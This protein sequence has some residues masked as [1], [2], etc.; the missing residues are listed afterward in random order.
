[1][2]PL[3]VFRQPSN[4]RV[5]TE[6]GRHTIRARDGRNVWQHEGTGVAT[7]LK[8]DGLHV[9]LSS[10]QDAVRY[11]E[12]RWQ[13]RIPEDMKYLGDHWERGY[14]D[15]S[16]TGM[17][18][19]KPMP[20][21]FFV[22]DGTQIFGCGV[23]TGAQAFCWWHV[24]PHGI[25]LWMDVRSGG[26]GVKL[27]QRKIE[28]ATVVERISQ[29]DE[30]P[31]EAAGHF[32][33]MLCDAPLLPPQPVYGANNCYYDPSYDHRSRERILQDSKLLADLSGNQANRPFS[34]ID[35]G[36]E[37]VGG[38]A[39]SPWR[40]GNERFPDMAGLANQI[41]KIGARPGIWYRPLL[42]NQDVPRSW[43]LSCRQSLAGQG[44]CIMDPTI[45]EVLERIKEDVA[46]MVGWGYELIKYGDTTHDA[47]GTWGG[48]MG[49]QITEDNWQF[50]DRSRTNAEILTSLYRS[51][52]EAASEA[53]LVGCNTVGHLCAGYVHV[54]RIGD[55]TS[56]REWLRTRKMGVN[57]LAFRAMQHG[58]LFATD[59]DCV[60]LTSQIPW[61]LNEQWMELLASSGTSMFIST[62][63]DQV[64]EKQ[65]TALSKAYDRASRPQA[66]VQP[67][68]WM[69]NSCPSRWK[70][71][72]EF[73]EFNWWSA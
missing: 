11:V 21:Y 37:N 1:M 47:L 35:E 52:R 73:F 70:S 18:P 53:L 22:F 42:A 66:L 6:S 4:V 26:M 61:R 63:A 54:Q 31:Y 50:S 71:G 16:W 59:A 67:L 43:A 12:L 13:Q 65:K 51:I 72:E 39:M 56:A 40:N 32:T 9:E 5:H 69:Q 34:I 58:R 10:P 64:K 17:T 19:D 24:D 38:L 33:A 27:G 28:M 14:G 2:I 60:G 30:T 23:K 8:D 48:V 57:S 68:D 36:W 46:L 7:R 3:T 25:T 20:W 62:Q 29:E 55:N 49:N 45:P 15:L 44:K 41:K